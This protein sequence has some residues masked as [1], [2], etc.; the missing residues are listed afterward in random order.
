[1][2]FL[3]ILLIIVLTAGCGGSKSSILDDTTP[4][5]DQLV[6]ELNRQLSTTWEPDFAPSARFD[7][8]TRILFWCLRGDYDLSGEVNVSDITPIAQYFNQPVDAEANPALI[9][10]A[11]WWVDGDN[12]GQVNISDITPVAQNFHQRAFWWKTSIGWGQPLGG[13]AGQFYVV[14]PP[15][16]DPETIVL[17]ISSEPPPVETPTNRSPIAILQATPDTGNVP[18]EVEFDAAASLDLDGHITKYEF[19]WEGDGIYDFVSDTTSTMSHTFATV[20]GY[21]SRLRVTDD[22]GATATDDQLVMVSEPGNLPP[23]AMLKVSPISGTVPATITLDASDSYDL[24]G[25][26]ITVEWDLDG[27]G[28]YDAT[29]VGLDST[30]P[31]Q[32]PYTN[33]GTFAPRI[34]VTDDKGAK[35]IAVGNSLSLKFPTEGNQLPSAVL[36][37]S[38]PVLLPGNAPLLVSFN[39]SASN[40]PDGS[41]VQYDFDFNNDGIWDAYDANSVVDWTYYTA[42]IFDAT[43]RVTD[44]NGAQDKATLRISVNVPGNIGPVA[45]LVANPTSGNTPLS[46]LFDA[47]A[48]NDSDGNVVRYDYDFNGDGI[49]DAYDAN[50][51]VGWT[52]YSAGIFNATVRVT[53]N[54]GAQDISTAEINVNI[55]GNAGP[56]ANLVATPISGDVPLSVFFDA[57]ASNDPDGSIVQYDY[58][59]NGDGIWD[60]YDANSAV[61]WTYYTT[62]IFHATVRVTDNSGTQDT[63]SVEITVSDPGGGGDETPT[64]HVV[65]L[66][67]PP[68]QNVI[69]GMQGVEWM[70]AEIINDS[71][72]ENIFVSSIRIEDTLGDAG[73]DFGALMNARI[74]ADMDG[75]GSCE[76]QLTNQM[77]FIDSGLPV[78]A[79][80]FSGVSGLVVATSIKVALRSDLS[81]ST[82]A[83]DAHTIRV[84][85]ITATGSNSG[86]SATGS[87]AGTG[88]TMTVLTSGELAVT[89]DSSSPLSR[90]LVGGATDVNLAVFRLFASNED[91]TLQQ[92][93]ITDDG[94]DDVAVA[95][96]F[97]ANR[98]SSGN[99]VTPF[100]VGTGYPFGGIATL[101][102]PGVTVRMPKDTFTRVY[103]KA[104]IATI[105]GSTVQNGDTVRVTIADPSQDVRTVGLYSGNA[106]SGNSSISRDAAEHRAYKSVPFVNVAANSPSGPLYPG[107][108][109]TIAIFNITADA[110]SDVS[111]ENADGNQLAVNIVTTINDYPAG[112]TSTVR[113][114]DQQTGLTLD[115]V[116]V[117]FGAGSNMA[118]VTF[119]FDGADLYIGAG[120][121]RVIYVTADTWALE[122]SG[123][124]IW[125]WLDDDDAANFSWGVDSAGNYATADITFRGDIRGNVL[126]RP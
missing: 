58:D 90:L 48:S 3:L 87:Y 115:S 119:D 23:V 73:D 57:S 82:T 40:D 63:D 51:F 93:T 98:D 125:A 18:L 39:A 102:L 13:Y 122:D 47:S 103:V 8:S 96:K 117:E 30:Q 21:H 91:Q 80:T 45:N 110:A 85:E 12:N 109:T 88:Q 53:D 64:F 104:D 60:A 10:T 94:D 4:L 89:V 62:G 55:L 43:V 111:L 100:L 114:K 126:V 35:S 95:Y 81:T 9:E 15:D 1:M 36:Y 124:F 84:S 79:F 67:T 34:R 31:R 121:T 19:D 27:D 71:T 50:S 72:S 7:P 69:A 46:V 99:V 38:I 11:P 106:I 20:G 77:Q 116:D 32:W 5:H 76:T 16:I 29:S 120:M 101:N 75:N 41:I 112:A 33:P 28:T 14:V 92:V 97:Y 65:T 70:Y 17:K 2:R 123:D 49:W 83:G 24:D 113:L 61:S 37:P 42:G 22:G 107:Y 78:E 105:D 6:A 52:F 108:D 68:A 66:E 118:T 74:M 59:F 26:I 44:N 86:S 25:D 54:N 56:I